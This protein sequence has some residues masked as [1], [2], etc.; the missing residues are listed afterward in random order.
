MMKNKAV[1]YISI[2]LA[3]F[4][5]LSCTLCVSAYI[6]DPQNVYRWNTKGVRYYSPVYSTVAAAKNYDY[7]YAIIGSSMVQ[8]M[9]AERFEKELGCKPLKLTIGAM[10]PSETLWLYKFANAQDKADNYLINI[11]LHRFAAATNVEPD[12]GRFPEHMYSDKGLIQFKYLLGFETWLRFIPLN[13]LLSVNSVL[14]LPLPEAFNRT[15]DE[16]TDINK[17]C[18]WDNTNPIGIEEM[19]RSYLSDSIA[20]NEGN[21]IEFTDSYAKNTQNFLDALLAELDEDETLTLLLPPYS[22][23]YWAKNSD[24]E[25][26]ILFELR[27]LIARFANEHDNIK[28]LDFQAEKYTADLD[29][30]IDSNHFGEKIQALIENDIFNSKDGHTVEQVKQNSQTILNYALSAREQ[31]TQYKAK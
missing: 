6:L 21:E 7:N 18:Q 4:L 16:A 9:S 1:K 17:M 3:V 5:G 13:I 29:K 19:Y 31:A 10:T 28:L 20:F 22:S 26:T 2:L 30:Y 12:S 8:N 24:K 11:D 14:A 15:I 23:L 25:T 27:E